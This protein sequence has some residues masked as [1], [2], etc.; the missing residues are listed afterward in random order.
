LRAFGIAS[1]GIACTPAL[2]ALVALHRPLR[3]LGLDLLSPL[4]RAAYSQ[5]RLARALAAG[6]PS[7]GM[8]AEGSSAALATAGRIASVEPARVLAARAA[9]D[10]E[11]DV[12]VVGGGPAGSTV[13]TFLARGGLSVRIVEREVFPRFRVGESLIPNCMPIL[14]R[15]GVLDRIKAH[16]FQPKFGVTFHDQELGAEHS[17]YFRDGRPW[18]NF[19]YDVHRADFDAILLDHAASQPGVRLLQPAR[20]ER[21]SLDGHGVTAEVRDVDGR[22]EIRA[23]FLVDAS[24]RDAFVPG[25]LGRRRP[26]SGLGK[27]AIFAYY[28][29]ARRFPGREEGNV[30]IYTF[31]E[32][33]FWWIPLARDETSVGCVLHA[34]TVKGREGSL[35]DLLASMIERCERVRDALVGA[36]RVTPIYTAAN[37]SYRME[38][39]VGDRF[40]C[41]GDSVGFVDP[42]FSAGVFLAMVAGEWGAE[43]ILRAFRENRFEARRLA[44]YE[45]RLDRAMRPFTRFIEG[46]YDPL[47]LELFL[48]PKDAFG[49]VDA[50]TFVLA[51]GAIRSIP[52]RMRLPLTV[53]F[54]VAR[55]HRWARRRQG[56]TTES[57]LEW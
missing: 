35:P 21:V 17:F 11:A 48:R 37:F 24:G 29:G 52:L 51:G 13:A 4:I 43:A 14:E 57:R 16:G 1:L 19:T 41:V 33:W 46:F 2:L 36:E 39:V 12:L 45:R 47:F 23:R 3:A 25:R 32:G 18:P 30:R 26:V 5:E 15:M 49:M 6:P 40:L 42:I 53:F 20:V 27:V 44:G 28:R 54:T 9:P 8:P 7:P 56:V 22:R 55:V 31:P 50:V 38:P 34:R 10:A